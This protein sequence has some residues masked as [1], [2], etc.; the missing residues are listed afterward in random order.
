[1][2]VQGEMHSYFCGVDKEIR[3]KDAKKRRTVVE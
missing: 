3:L 2:N 1:M